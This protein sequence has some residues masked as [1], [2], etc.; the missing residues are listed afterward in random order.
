MNEEENQAW[1]QIARR[2]KGRGT[3]GTGFKADI[4]AGGR[5]KGRRRPWPKGS[6]ILFGLK[7]KGWEEKG[8]KGKSVIS[9]PQ[10]EIRLDEKT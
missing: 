4:E 6:N 2:T 10:K 1:Q 5:K 3:G 7:E 8:Y 9:P